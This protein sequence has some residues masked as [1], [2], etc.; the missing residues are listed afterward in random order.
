MKTQ[1]IS[2]LLIIGLFQ[3]SV[4]FAQETETAADFDKHPIVYGYFKQ[5]SIPLPVMRLIRNFFFEDK[6]KV[7]LTTQGLI[8]Q[9][10]TP[11]FG[12]GGGPK[13]YAPGDT[14]YLGRLPDDKSVVFTFKIESINLKFSKNFEELNPGTQPFKDTVVAVTATDGKRYDVTVA[15]GIEKDFVLLNGRDTQVVSYH[16]FIQGLQEIPAGLNSDL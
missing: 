5:E 9:N 7:L 10:N 14:Q 6:D 4:I 3:L 11:K 15:V 12:S 1:K 16:I 13:W 2:A 8:E